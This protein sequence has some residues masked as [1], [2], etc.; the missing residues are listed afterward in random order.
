MAKKK[1]EKVFQHGI[2][3]TKPWSKEMYAHNDK[4]ATEVRDEIWERWAK[5]YKASKAEYDAYNEFLPEQDFT[6][7]GFEYS[8]WLSH[9]TDELVSLQ[10]AVIVIGYGPGFEMNQVNK[11]FIDDLENAPYYRLNEIVEE[12]DIELE[13]GFVGFK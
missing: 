9:R 5:A 11:D 2:E 6:P 4:V 3:I 1:K 7:G 8:E 12:L 10:E 13:E